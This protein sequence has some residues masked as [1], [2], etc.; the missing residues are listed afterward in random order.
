MPHV[1]DA[2]RSGALPLVIFAAAVACSPGRAGGQTPD[3]HEH[4]ADAADAADAVNEVESQP[5]ATDD[6]A[7]VG[8]LLGGRHLAL[9]PARP[10]APGD[11]AR[12][13]GVAAELRQSLAKYKDVAAAE[14]DGYRR[15][16]PRVRQQPVYHYVNPQRAWRERD[17]FVPGEPGTLLYRQGRG[18]RLELVGAMYTAARDATPEELDRRVPLSVA[19]WHAHVNFCVVRRAPGDPAPAGGGRWGR[20]FTVRPEIT[21]RAACDQAGGRFVPQLF[22]WMVHANVFAGD[23]PEAVWGHGMHGGGTGH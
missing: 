17:E 20:R 14:A 3:R 23:T 4:G 1:L 22:G 13:A 5:L 6:H 7:L 19:R 8:A 11:S 2:L 21:T 10:P 12:A 15:F 9:S 18:G 16:A